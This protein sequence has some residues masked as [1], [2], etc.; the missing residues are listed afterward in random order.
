MNTAFDDN[1]FEPSDDFFA[2]TLKAGMADGT[3]YLS[4]EEFDLSEVS[5][6]FDEGKYNTVYCMI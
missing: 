5:N 3:I 4:D 1:D 2:D 6:I